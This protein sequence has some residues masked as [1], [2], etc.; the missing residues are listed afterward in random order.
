[1]AKIERADLGLGKYGNGR[2]SIEKRV[3]KNADLGLD[4][5]IGTGSTAKNQFEH[6]GIKVSNI[7]NV[8][9]IQNIVLQ[10]HDIKHQKTSEGPSF[11]TV[12]ATR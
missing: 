2:I 5:H 1:V 3:M 7:F 9:D 4:D 10:R 6:P 12:T 11:I 8:Q